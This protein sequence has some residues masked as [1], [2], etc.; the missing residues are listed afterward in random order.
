MNNTVK[1]ASGRHS[2][3]KVKIFLT[4]AVIIIAITFIV[5]PILSMI[6]TSLIPRN[7]LYKSDLNIFKE[8]TLQNYQFVI[9]KTNI[10]LNMLNSF[11]IAAIATLI[12][13]VISSLAAYALSRVKSK[14]FTFYAFFLIIL[15]TFPL[16]LMIIPLFSLFKQFGLT[17]SRLSVVIAYVAINLPFSIWMMRGIFNGIS[18]EIEESALVEGASL[19]RAFFR[20]IVPIAVPGLASVAIFTFIFSWNEFMFAN[21]FLTSDA[22]KPVT[23]GVQAFMQQFD[24]QWTLLMAASTLSTIPVAIFIIF[25]QK[26]IV[27][28]LTAGAVKG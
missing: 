1:S 24:R 14:F 9:A 26:Y 6:S 27:Q 23:V 11:L 7:V 20:I 17:N 4:Y 2:R 16:M 12:C 3:H 21:I 19:L 5:L 8:L 13:T 22:I 10:P 28:G 15:Y 25:T 18:N